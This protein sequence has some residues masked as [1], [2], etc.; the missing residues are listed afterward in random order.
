[1]SK[2][3]D[4]EEV[5]MMY[6]NYEVCSNYKIH[7][8]CWLTGEKCVAFIETIQV[9]KTVDKVDENLKLRCPGYNLPEEIATLV[10]KY[11]LMNSI[12]DCSTARKKIDKREKALLNQLKSI[13]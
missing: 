10:E 13:S 11:H 12:E 1:M 7:G 2:I 9:S 6:T 4:D 8:D 5:R 3:F